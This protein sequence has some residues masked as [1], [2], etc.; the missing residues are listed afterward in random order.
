[1]SR[2]RF[3]IV[4][5]LL[6]CLVPALASATETERFHKVIPMGPGGTLKLHS[7][8]GVVRVTGADVAQV[9]VD[10]TRRAERDRLDHIKL[11]IQANGSELTINANQRDKGWTDKN[12]N[13]VETEFEISVPNE[14][15][16]DV[17]AFSSDV[18][19]NAVRGKQHV[20]ARGAAG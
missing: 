18:T 8:S 6:A 19:I 15:A 9:T 14:T 10:A 7:F 17:D 20:H 16:L 12:N 5:L 2:S 3:L 11:D 4:E 13:V 1:M